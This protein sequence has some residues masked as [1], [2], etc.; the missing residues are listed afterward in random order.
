MQKVI[1]T[2]DFIIASVKGS[3]CR[4]YFWCICKEEAINLLKNADLSKENGSS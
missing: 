1:S 3:E 2:N 4:I